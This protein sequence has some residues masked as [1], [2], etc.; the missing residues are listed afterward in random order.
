M[1]SSPSS[2]SFDVDNQS[3]A[4]EYAFNQSI[5]HSAFVAEPGYWGDAIV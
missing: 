4:D 3:H 1:T 2:L 5:N